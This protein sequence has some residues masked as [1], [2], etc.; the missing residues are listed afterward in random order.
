MFVVLETDQEEQFFT[1]EELFDKL[2][3]ILQNYPKEVP[4][5]LQKFSNLEEQATYL[6]DNFCEL[7]IG[8]NGY[9]QWYVVRLEK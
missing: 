8:E 9:L 3:I 2:K 4:R 7:D 6:R 1:P 5:E